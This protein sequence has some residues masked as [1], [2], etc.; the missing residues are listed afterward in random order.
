VASNVGFGFLRESTLVHSAAPPQP[1]H[2]QPAVP[3]M[4]GPGAA[5]IPQ[6]AYIWAP[7]SQTPRHV[8]KNLFANEATD[9]EASPDLKML[10]MPPQTPSG[11][12]SPS[13]G[14]R[15]RSPSKNSR[16]R[17]PSKGY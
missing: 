17:S 10:M 15:G 1:L 7:L 4:M 3:P 9:S 16:G 5:H 13:K 6:Q 2:S 11:R 14:D 8:R 12:R